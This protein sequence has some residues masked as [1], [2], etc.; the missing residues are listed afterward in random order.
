MSGHA[1]FLNPRV[2][3]RRSPEIV[4]HELAH[5]WLHMGRMESGG[6]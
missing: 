6:K 4:A 1:I 2:S 3:I 5:V